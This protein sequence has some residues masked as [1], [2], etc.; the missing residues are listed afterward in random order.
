MI[1][2]CSYFVK[3][4][5]SR[6]VCSTVPWITIKW[7]KKFVD[8]VGSAVYYRNCVP[9][10]TTAEFI[11]KADRLG[12]FIVFHCRMST[13]QPAWPVCTTSER[14]NTA[15]GHFSSCR[16]Y[17]TIPPF[18]ELVITSLLTEGCCKAAF[19]IGITQ[20]VIFVT[21]VSCEVERCL[22]K[23]SLMPYNYSCLPTDNSALGKR[24]SFPFCELRNLNLSLLFLK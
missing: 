9:F 4:F 19:S 8:K 11:A 24:I 15:C 1:Y 16:F 6:S 5:S 13:I 12:N 10:F 14:W 21:C 23:V 20:I 17:K 7:L 3:F 18:T 2:K 22:V